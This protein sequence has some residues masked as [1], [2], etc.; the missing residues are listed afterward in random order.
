[1]KNEDILIKRETNY[2]D[3]KMNVVDPY[4]DYNI[5]SY[6]EYRRLFK[7]CDMSLAD[8]IRNLEVNESI[9]IDVRSKEDGLEM[10]KWFNAN[11]STIMIRQFKDR[12]YVNQFEQFER[13]VVCT[14][15]K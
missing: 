12:K 6:K 8:V 13:K 11:T 3:G 10:C 7:D 4:I 14:R 2:V 1:M 9:I 5:P 15:T